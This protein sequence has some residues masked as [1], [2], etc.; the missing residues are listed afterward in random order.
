M[1]A[2]KIENIFETAKKNT[3]NLRAGQTPEISFSSYQ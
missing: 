2:A 1:H 3:K